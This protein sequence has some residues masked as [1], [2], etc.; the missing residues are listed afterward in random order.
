MNCGFIALWDALEHYDPERDG[1]F[2]YFYLFH[3]TGAIYRENGLN[4]GGHSPDGKRRFD[5]AIAKDTLRLDAETDE[6][7]ENG[8]T[9][10]DIL[11]AGEDDY[12]SEKRVVERIFA[13]Q[14]HKTLESL[15]DGLPREERILIRQKYYADQDRAGIAAQLHISRD[16]AVLLEDRALLALRRNGKAVGLDQF[17]DSRI[18]YYAGTG[19]QRFKETR[20]SST[21]RI[22]IKRMEME[23]RYMKLLS[24]PQEIS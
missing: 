14:L 13:E 12:Y 20:S 24:E 9:L 1:R 23:E 15:I 4:T 10:L 3:L 8:G 21:E 5:P 17:L 7:K 22:T 18:N 16:E 6:S 11:P 19:V 2:T